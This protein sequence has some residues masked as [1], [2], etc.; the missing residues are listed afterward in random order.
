MTSHRSSPPRPVAAGRPGANVLHRPTLKEPPSSSARATKSP[1]KHTVRPRSA[2]TSAPHASSSSSLSEHSSARAQN[3]LLG[4]PCTHGG[5]EPCFVP[6]TGWTAV[7]APPSV[8]APAEWAHEAEEGVRSPPWSPW[9][10]I[11]TGAVGN[12]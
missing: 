3:L 11:R 10:S 6:I 9:P 8:R 5:G 4:Q 1:T 2:L 7:H 12:L